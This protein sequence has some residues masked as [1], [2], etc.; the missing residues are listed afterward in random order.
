MG[1]VEVRNESGQSP[2][3][4]E[5]NRGIIL[6]VKHFLLGRIADA[7]GQI[8]RK[9]EAKRR[10]G[11]ASYSLNLTSYLLVVLQPTCCTIQSLSSTEYQVETRAQCL[12]KKSRSCAGWAREP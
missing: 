9:Q 1:E 12:W 3:F 7:K 5:A 6:Y 11:R 4:C 2:T 10:G 8:Q